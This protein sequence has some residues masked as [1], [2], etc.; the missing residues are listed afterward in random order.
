VKGDIDLLL[1]K[2][3][4]EALYILREGSVQGVPVEIDLREQTVLDGKIEPSQ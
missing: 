2:G 1:G 4:G 3:L